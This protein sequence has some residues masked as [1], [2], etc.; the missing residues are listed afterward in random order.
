[1]TTIVEKLPD[2][3]TAL[4]A[5]V[6]VAHRD[7]NRRLEESVQSKLSREYGIELHFPCVESVERDLQWAGVTP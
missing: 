4:I 2:G 5:L 7:G 1:M 3:A 6:R